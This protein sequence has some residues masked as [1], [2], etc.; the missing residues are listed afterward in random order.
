MEKPIFGNIVGVTAPSAYVSYD[1]E[2]NLSNEQKIQARENIGA[3]SIIDVVELPTENIRED[4]LY[5]LLT[6][7]FYDKSSASVHTSEGYKCIVVNEHPEIGSPAY[8]VATKQ[9]LAYYEIS[10]NS[11]IAYVDENLASLTGGLFTPGWYSVDILFSALS[12]GADKYNGVINDTSVLADIEQ[13]EGLY[14]L[15]ETT[16]HH[17][18]NNKWLPL[19]GVGWHGTGSQAEVFNDLVNEASSPYSH[20]EG[21]GTCARGTAAHAEGMLTVAEGYSTH[22][23]GSDCV[24]G[25]DT[26]H[27]EGS[28]TQALGGYSHTEGHYTQAQGEASHAEGEGTYANSAHQHVQGKYNKV[29]TEEKYAHIVGNGEDANNRS[30]A[31]TLDW[32]GNAWFAGDVYVGSTSGTNK[33]EGS[34]K[35]IA[36]DADGNVSI[37]GNLT[38]KG[39]TYTQDNETLRIADNIIELNSTKVDNSTTLSGLAINKDETSTYGVMYDPTDDTVKFGE[40]STTD[41]VFTF[42][43][44]EGAPI[45]VRDD[46]S[47]LDDGAIMIF[48]KSKNRLVNS[49][50]TI[51]TFKQWIKDYIDEK[52]PTVTAADEGKF[53]RVSSDGKLVAETIPSTKEVAF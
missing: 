22:A 25:G 45:A 11:A 26:A 41:G 2:M 5:R 39:T 19:K 10:S 53:I 37:T 4:V 48:D 32:S 16:L 15:L 18:S 38:V 12:N 27:A 21:Q 34:K 49:G 14:L 36:E 3:T 52:I 9:C 46:S 40:G 7:T 8:D 50:Y 17:Y 6:G 35:L 31:H 30:N 1:Q 43:E 28:Y 42:G 24:A 47:K 29:D 44:G 33:D 23:E 51:D 20:A 13:P